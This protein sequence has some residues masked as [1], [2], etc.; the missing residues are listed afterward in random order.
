MI[1]RLKDKSGRKDFHFLNKSHEL[2]KKT[3]NITKH[4][5]CVYLKAHKSSP[6]RTHGAIVVWKQLNS[7]SRGARSVTFH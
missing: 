6:Q 3:K 2:K 7:Y 1:L 4:L 5:A